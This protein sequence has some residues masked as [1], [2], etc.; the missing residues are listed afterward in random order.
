[1]NSKRFGAIWGALTLAALS[2]CG[3][4]TASFAPSTAGSSLASAAVRANGASGATAEFVIVVPAH[5]PLLRAPAY[6]SAATQGLSVAVRAKGSSKTERFFF[7]IGPAQSYCTGGTPSAPLVCR[8]SARV[9]AGNDTFVLDAYD[10]SNTRAQILSTVT[11]AHKLATGSTKT[12]G[13]SMGGVVRYVLLAIDDAYP[14]L[15]VNAS[16]PV[17]LVAADAYGYPIIGSYANPISL[18]D[19]DVS[20]VTKLSR[21]S[22]SNSSQASQVTLIYSGARLKTHAVISASASGATVSS[23]RASDT[24]APGSNGIIADPPLLLVTAGESTDAELSGPGT[25]APFV[26]STVSNAKRVAACRGLVD[27]NVSDDAF[28]VTGATRLGACGLSAFDSAGHA[29]TVPVLVSMAGV[30]ASPTPSPSPSTQP[31]TSANPT[32]SPTSRPTSSPTSRPTSGPSSSPTPIPG[33]IAVTPNAVTLCP[34]TG[35]NS[36]DNDIATVTV[37]QPNFDG[38]FTET[39]DC[40]ANDA[41]VTPISAN[42]PSAVFSISGTSHTGTC[43]AIFTGGGGKQTGVA[44]IISPPGIHINAQHH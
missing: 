4:T 6:V 17:S 21:A 2:A 25:K 8:V 9:P 18:S 31:T 24:F 32:S 22:I 7:K 23:Q 5:P 13:F 27:V 33:A 19:S 20:G 16:I 11:I 10:G 30:A 35:S 1:L 15:G 38:A 40:A 28:V 29:R 37:T 42:G 41:K 39:D 14:A 34:S 3:G 43:R 44:V 12:I 36:C 26:F